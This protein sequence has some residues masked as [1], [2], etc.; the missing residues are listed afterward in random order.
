[1]VQET[2]LK[3]Q[4]TVLYSTDLLVCVGYLLALALMSAMLVEGQQGENLHNTI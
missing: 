4:N 1:M 2:E 3:S